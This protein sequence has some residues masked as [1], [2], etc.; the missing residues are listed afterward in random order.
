M[1]IS[2]NYLSI[3]LKLKECINSLMNGNFLPIFSV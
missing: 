1:E 2:E 3:M